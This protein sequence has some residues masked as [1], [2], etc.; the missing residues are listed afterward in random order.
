M[1]PSRSSRSDEKETGRLEAFSDGVFAIAITL[2]ILEIQVPKGLELGRL[3]P[4]LLQLWPAYLA[5]LT[6]FA[7][8]GIIWINHHQMFELLRRSNQTLLLLNLLLLL[9][10]TFLP[11]P[12]QLVA[13]YM[14]HPDE[15]VAVL[16]YTATLLL[17]GVFFNLLWRYITLNPNLLHSNADHETVDALSRDFRFGPLF[18]LA[19]MAVA[20]FSATGSLLLILGAAVFFALPRKR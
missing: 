13:E 10:V 5:F 7:T 2:L 9:G 12:T 17:I 4:A 19:A 15:S 1:E 20:Y 14:G 11:Y 8:I 18:N 6:S 3:T 16:V